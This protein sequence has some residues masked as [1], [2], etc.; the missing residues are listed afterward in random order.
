LETGEIEP[1]LPITDIH[2]KIYSESK[3]EGKKLIYTIEIF[4]DIGRAFCIGLLD[5]V[6]KN[7]VSRVPMS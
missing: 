5:Y 4:E 3:G 2:S 6:G 7:P 1:E